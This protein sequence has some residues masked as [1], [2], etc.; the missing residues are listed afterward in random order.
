M[1]EVSSRCDGQ[2]GQNKSNAGG[3]SIGQNRAKVLNSTSDYVPRS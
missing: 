3:K 2:A 1:P